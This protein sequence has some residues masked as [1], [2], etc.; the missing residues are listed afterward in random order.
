M[1][2]EEPTTTV[3]FIAVTAD[4][5]E[6][7]INNGELPPD[8]QGAHVDMA[9]ENDEVQQVHLIAVD[10]AGSPVTDKMI[11][12]TAAE[13]AG[14]VFIIKDDE[15]TDQ[16]IN[17]LDAITITNDPSN[18]MRV[19]VVM[20]GDNDPNSSM[21][22]I[23]EKYEIM[24]EEPT[25][26][27]PMISQDQNYN[28]SYSETATNNTTT[29]SG[30]SFSPTSRTPRSKKK[31]KTQGELT[32]DDLNFLPPPEPEP[33][34]PKRKI[35]KKRENNK[36]SDQMMNADLDSLR[37]SVVS[38]AAFCPHLPPLDPHLPPPTPLRVGVGGGGK[39]CFFSLFS[40]TPTFPHLPPRVPFR[41]GVGG[42]RW[43]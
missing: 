40:P 34:S 35:A 6:R 42:D 30:N 43:G 1:E 37:G 14:I 10:N 20:L 39:I 4:E 7:M 16:N 29:A 38:G 27:P 41:V 17:I 24:A 36:S 3:Q 19:S 21:D 2:E 9:T 33:F 23:N 31:R 11:L 8:V 22:E 15:G 5:H 26:A 18:R 32:E 28:S 25:G 13:Q 12:Q